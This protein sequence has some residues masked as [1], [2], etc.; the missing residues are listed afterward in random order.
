[1][2]NINEVIAKSKGYVFEHE[3][4]LFILD[5]KKDCPDYLNDARLYMALFEE[6]A[7]QGVEPSLRFD[8]ALGWMVDWQPQNETSLGERL[9]SDT[10]GIAICLAYMKLHGLE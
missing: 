10:I 9:I 5:A 1:M 6:M 3:N 2:T 7:T 4:P 8:D